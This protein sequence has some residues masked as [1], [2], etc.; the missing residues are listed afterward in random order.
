MNDAIVIHGRIPTWRTWWPAFG[1]ACGFAL[2]VYAGLYLSLQDMLRA[3]AKLE[4]YLAMGCVALAIVDWVV[5][6]QVLGFRARNRN[7]CGRIVL[8]RDDLELHGAR[9]AWTV[10]IPL[11]QTPVHYTLLPSVFHKGSPEDDSSSAHAYAEI[12]TG[13]Q[14]VLIESLD[15]SLSRTKFART[16]FKLVTQRPATDRVIQLRPADFGTLIGQFAAI[17]ERA[18]A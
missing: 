1:L 12:G 13:D 2:A 14:S 8:D 5:L 11:P 18:K 17:A 7:L 4:Q 10:K 6:A 3:D 16:S 9:D 15:F